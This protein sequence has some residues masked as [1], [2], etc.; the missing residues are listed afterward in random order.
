MNNK[1][2][3]GQ[4]VQTRGIA[5]EI[6]NDENF[7]KEIA[8]AFSKYLQC[9]WGDTCEEDCEMNNNAVKFNNDRI[10]AKYITTKGNVFII[11]EYDRSY[12]T[13]MFAHEY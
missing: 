13:I 10:L 12:T 1:F 2:D 3:L 11:T 5:T 8:E 6:E 4:I 9:N 7:A